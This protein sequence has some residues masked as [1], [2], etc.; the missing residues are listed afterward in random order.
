MSTNRDDVISTDDQGHHGHP[1]QQFS[2]L[3]ATVRKVKRGYA[4]DVLSRWGS[5]QGYLEEHGRTER[6]YRAAELD[7]LLRIGI[8]EIKDDSDLSDVS[9][10]LC[11][12]IRNAIYAAQDAE[13]ED[14]E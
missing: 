14:A 2:E 4:L 6:Q 3:S 10:S 9:A 1:G 11:Q 8:S 5:N 12:A 7:D 13:D